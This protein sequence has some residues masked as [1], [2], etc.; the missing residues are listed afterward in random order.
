MTPK[1]FATEVH[2]NDAIE[3]MMLANECSVR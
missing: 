2:E 1:D 3:P